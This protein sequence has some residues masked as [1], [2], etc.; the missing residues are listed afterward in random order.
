MKIL[1]GLFFAFFVFRGTAQQTYDTIFHPIYGTTQLLEVKPKQL[2]PDT[3]A[4]ISTVKNCSE[5]VSIPIYV[6]RN[7]LGEVTK[8]YNDFN[9]LDKNLFTRD[10]LH[11]EPPIVHK[12]KAKNTSNNIG[13][14][15]SG[16]NL[17]YPI[18]ACTFNDNN[19]CTA[20]KVGL[21]DTLGNE[22][23]P[24]EFDRIEYIDSTFIFKRDNFYYLHDV[25][26]KP[27]NSMAYDSI[28]YSDFVHNHLIVKK[29]G[30]YGIVNRFG[31][32]I[33]PIKYKVVQKSRFM[34][35]Y[36]EFLEGNK[37]GFI[38]WDSKRYLA[39]F[40]PSAEIY[41]RDGFFVFKGENDWNVIDSTGKYF[42]K[43][44]LQV[45]NI[46]NKNRFIVGPNYLERALVDSKNRFI[47]DKFYHDIWK[48]N[49]NTL[50]VG[51][52]P[53]KIDASDLIKSAKWQ[54]YDVDFQLKNKNSYKTIQKIDDDFLKVWDQKNNFHLV[55]DYGNEVVDLNV[56]DAYKYGDGIYKLVVDGK[57]IFIDL[58]HPEKRS[59]YYDNLRCVT[60]NRI[61]VQKDG[62]WGFID[63]DFKE[64]CPI[65]ANNVSCFEDGIATIE[66][67][68]QYYIMDSTGKL[69]YA[70]FFDFAENVKNGYYRVRRDG[71][72]GL[73]YKKGYLTVPLIYEENNFLV[74]Q[75]GSYY[76]G[77]RK[78]KGIGKYGI[79]NQRNEII[80]PFIYDNCVEISAYASIE[81][82]RT[83][84]FFAFATIEK[85]N[86]IEN[87]YLNFDDSKSSL[88][89]QENQSKGFKIV[90]GPC[91]NKES[92]SAKCFGV[93]NWLGKQIIPFS[94]TNIKPLKKNTF[95]VYSSTGG[96]I[97][98]TNGKVIIPPVYNYVYELCS[99]CNFIQVGRQYGGWGLYDYTGNLIADTLYGSFDK[100]VFDLIPFR[101]HPNYHYDV[102][103]K[104][105]H[106]EIK[107]GFMDMTGKVV[108]EPSYERYQIPNQK[109]EEI[110]LI[111]GNVV[112]KINGKGEVLEGTLIV[113]E[114]NSSDSKTLVK[115]SKCL[116]FK[117][118]NKPRFL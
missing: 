17:V 44:N 109:K 27:I 110:L 38:S 69:V 78:T 115:K 101:N 28:I 114:N 21:I 80:Y 37:Y 3:K 49:E 39:P 51:S 13:N 66:V 11:K 103:K 1:V 79:V 74:R 58:K 31:R 56:T 32:E 53:G 52:E 100:P 35:G 67:M 5:L 7:N 86:T 10:Q 85:R 112:T 16:Y 18:Y 8:T 76:L 65:K 45:F 20:F 95:I 40:S 81:Q 43:S 50:M 61:A 105:V 26:F 97:L 82:K 36:Y 48:I 87:Y 9:H 113:K 118:K 75:N 42:L 73:F 24:A 14:D 59:N 102:N 89:I 98:D 77:V 92:N 62:L 55:D 72:Y 84:G 34:T 47:S 111:N 70:D 68:K 46:V 106:D 93:V 57:H 96:G 90:E 30:L 116:L 104:F 117:R 99:D 63:F 25:K 64:I 108:I 15:D 94:Y 22:I 29:N 23:V 6:I 2:Y 19:S 12:I 4:F 88:K 41:A 107:Y 60:E 54:L 91:V 71:K 33:L 83:D